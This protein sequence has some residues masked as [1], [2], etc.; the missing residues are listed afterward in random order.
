MF[1]ADTK[2]RSETAKAN[3]EAEV[4]KREM[5]G[6]VGRTADRQTD[7]QTLLQRSRSRPLVHDERNCGRGT[8]CNLNGPI[9]V[10][11][12][13]VR[14]PKHVKVFNMDDH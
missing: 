1:P 8:R 3:D 6:L 4:P 2:V 12:S 14:K 5:L 9:G 7:R 10:K 13:S 11:E